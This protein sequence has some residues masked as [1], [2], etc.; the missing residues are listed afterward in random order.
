MYMKPRDTYR[1][2]SEEIGSDES[3]EDEGFGKS[4]MIPRNVVNN[5]EM[6]IYNN[7]I[8]ADLVLGSYFKKQIENGNIKQTKILII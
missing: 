1:Y 8:P 6:L 7:D 5:E 2:V 3:E 4:N